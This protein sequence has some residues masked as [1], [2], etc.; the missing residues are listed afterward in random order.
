M[1][2]IFSGVLTAFCA[3][4]LLEAR[5]V[6]NLPSYAA[7]GEKLYGPKG[8][9]IVNLALW[10][11]QT[12]FCTGYVY[13]IVSNVHAI[14]NFSHDRAWTAVA[15]GVVFTLLAWVRKIELFA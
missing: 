12:G 8:K 4:L 10:L 13:F 3:N 5:K 1:V 14:G 7:I 6:V 2:I 9:H 11:S 15:C